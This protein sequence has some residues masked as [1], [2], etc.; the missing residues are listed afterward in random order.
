MKY[1]VSLII[2][3]IIMPLLAYSQAITLK[4][5]GEGEAL[6]GAHVYANGKIVTATNA[7]GIAAINANAGDKLRISY[8]GYVD[9]TFVLTQ[10]M[11]SEGN[12]I[13]N[14]QLQVFNIDEIKVTR[15]KNDIDI[16]KAK[17]KKG[18]KIR[19]S[20]DII[21]FTSIDTLLDINDR[22]FCI[23]I[24]GNTTL[25]NMG[26]NPLISINSIKLITEFKDYTAD[27]MKL[28]SSDTTKLEFMKQISSRIGNSL[29]IAFHIYTFKK[30]KVIY[31]G[32]EEN[33]DVFYFSFTKKNYKVDG[34]VYLN[35]LGVIERINH[36]FIASTSEY[37]T[38][39]LDTS[40]E[41]FSSDNTILPKSCLRKSYFFNNNMEIRQ[42]ESE[43]LELFHNNKQ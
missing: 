17:L 11:I 30:M 9:E 39:H 6:I 23:I 7:N 24:M 8:I 22:G 35:E 10:K 34:L 20:S 15:S 41:Y 28:E 29:A 43:S 1:R 31:R 18:L 13:I 12:I 37:T 38:Y 16:L 36:N 40:F 3:F 14:M 19:I 2:C 25:K 26:K 33:K 5:T 4:V 42:I 32:K 27:T 21:N